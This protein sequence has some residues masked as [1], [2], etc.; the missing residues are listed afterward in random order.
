MKL[1]YKILKQNPNSREGI[2]TTTSWLGI[3]TNLLVA[4]VKIII[5][6]LASS[7]AIVS[8]G[9]NNAA[10]V[11]SSVITLVG[12]KLAAKHPDEKHPFGYGRIEYLTGLVISVLI[13]V[14]GIEM[15]GNSINLIFNPEELN[16]SYFSLAI[17]FVSAIVK[18]V[19]GKYTIKQGKS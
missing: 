3:L 8:E 15:L 10:D 17:V 1:L 9:V 2:I 13:L 11:F 7:I 6:A 12:T 14:T 19:L 18:F 5:G 4:S 16:I